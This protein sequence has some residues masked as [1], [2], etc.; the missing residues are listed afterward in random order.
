VPHPPYVPV[1]P[2]H[3]EGRQR[4]E[5]PSA[6]REL[7]I[8]FDSNLSDC[9]YC[10]HLMSLYT[11]RGFQFLVDC[12]AD[13]RIL[14]DA[15]GARTAPLGTAPAYRWDETTDKPY[16]GQGR[17]WQGNRIAH[18]LSRPP[19]PNIGAV[20]DLWDELCLSHIDIEPYLPYG[21]T[22]TV[23]S[24]LAALP[25]P[26]VLAD[27]ATGPGGSAPGIP[28]ATV[29][30]F[31]R[32][33]L[34]RCDGSLV[35]LDGNRRAP[36]LASY[37][38]RHVDE[39]GVGTTELLLALLTQ[40]DLLIS[41]DGGSLSLARCSHIPAIGVWLPDHYPAH[42]ALPRREQLNLVLAD[43]TAR[44]N[45]YKRIPWNLVEHPGSAF[46]P[47]DLADC[48]QLMLNR[49]RYLSRLDIAADIQLQQFVRQWCRALHGNALCS[50][51]DRHRSLDVLLQELGRRFMAPTVVETGTMRAEEDWA[52]AGSFTYL[53]GAYLYR[54]GGRLYS[55]DISAPHCTFSRGWTRVFG[56]TVTVT[57]Q[58][59]VSFLRQ[60]T[61]PIDLLYL[62]SLDATEPGHAEQAFA[63][64]RAALPKLHSNSLVVFDD[65]PCDGGTWCGKGAIGVPY[66]LQR[67][68][69]LLYAGYQAV[70]H[71]GPGS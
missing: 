9:A 55:V 33:F 27:I 4:P 29:F 28:D 56:A 70:L 25:R 22:R 64:L 57:H 66:L 63:E 71:G 3:L 49:P 1:R 13:K 48:C 26:I 42:C 8:G 44:W 46:A 69:Q 30:Q 12:P 47:G 16:A 37:R 2:A 36:R 20:E 35:L 24:W 41:V 10:A 23:Q 58:D 61:D 43:H 15:A 31:Y 17:F 7:H 39:L 50:Y 11:R 21:V 59:A 51:S 60:F 54:S 34:D 53:A 18:H 38:I 67:G 14:F 32:L 65:T 45:R 5:L 68:W 62:D 52:G 6:R 19:L 40:A